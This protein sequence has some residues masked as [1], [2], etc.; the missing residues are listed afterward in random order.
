MSRGGGRNG[1]IYQQ[2]LGSQLTEMFHS[3]IRAS[4]AH[5]FG[6]VR[7]T[8]CAGVNIPVYST[9]STHG[10]SKN[11]I[12]TAQA[13]HK[14][15][16]A[17]GLSGLVSSG[18][19][20]YTLSRMRARSVDGAGMFPTVLTIGAAADSHWLYGANGGAG[21]IWTYWLNGASVS[22][23]VT[24]DTNV[25]T[26]E[27]W[28]DG[29]LL[30]IR[31]DGTDHTASSAQ[32]MPANATKVQIGTT[33]TAINTTEATVSHWLHLV[34]AGGYPGDAVCSALRAHALAE[35]SA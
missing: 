24:V 17:T 2:I 32:S 14:Y 28:G 15:M 3:Q 35:F 6:A 23:G 19:R 11:C 8:D 16:S 31:I 25:H 20:P 18:Q 1:T 26:I 10:S 30:H 7:G 13:G 21:S 12:Q 29:S 34:C 9:D 5:Q 22:S 33:I 4:A 27:C